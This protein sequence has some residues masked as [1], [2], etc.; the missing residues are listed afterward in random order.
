MVGESDFE[1]AATPRTRRSV[2]RARR[3]RQPAAAAGDVVALRR[4]QLDRKRAAE[5]DVTAARREIRQ[6]TFDHRVA[7]ARR[8]RPWSAGSMP[9]RTAPASVAPCE[10][11]PW[12]STNGSARTTPGW[13]RGP[14]CEVP[15][16]RRV[17]GRRQ[18]RV[19]GERKEARAQLALEPVHDR[20]DGDERSDAEAD[21]GERDPADERHE[22]LVLAG[23]DVAQPEPQGQRRQ[24]VR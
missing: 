16:R 24:H 20:Q 11:S 12:T 14:C 23:A 22:I 19:R 8:L 17:G 21:P 1:T 6:A 7:Q 13:P 10:R 5:R 9:R 3:P 2:A 4:L 15:Q 18:R